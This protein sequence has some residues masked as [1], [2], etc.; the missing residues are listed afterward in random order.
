MTIMVEAAYDPLDDFIAFLF[1]GLEGLIY[2]AAKTLPTGEDDTTMEW[3]QEF[4]NY[5]EDITK[6]KRVIKEVSKTHEIYLAPAL[7]SSPKATKENF[8]VS[9]VIWADF[10]LNLQTPNNRQ[11][12]SSFFVTR[13]CKY[14][15]PVFLQALYRLR[16]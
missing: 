13:K 12:T 7:F 15:A 10:D 16:R 1:E 2:V 14:L 4:F 3:K 8:K 9:N 11:R 5:P 6:V